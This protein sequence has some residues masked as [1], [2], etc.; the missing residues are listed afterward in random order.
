MPENRPN[1][2]PGPNRGMS[3][4]VETAAEKARGRGR[5]RG[6]EAKTRPEIPADQFSIE[7]LADTDL[8]NYRRRR[9]ERSDQQVAVDNM[10]LSVFND[11]RLK[12]SPSDWSKMPV[13]RWIVD[14]NVDET[15]RFMLRKAAALHG[16]RLIFGREVFVGGKS[17]ITFI[18]TD[19][20]E[21]DPEQAEEATSP[22]SSPAQS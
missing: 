13:R 4:N 16:K 7:V 10:V 11:W 19:R 1:P 14:K 22:E 6:S 3:A 15:A 18:V 5:P 8:G 20:K 9:L 21:K 17:H 12:G 2:T